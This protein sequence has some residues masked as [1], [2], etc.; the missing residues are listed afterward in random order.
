MRRSCS[1]P[2][3]RGWTPLRLLASL[4][5]SLQDARVTGYQNLGRRLSEQRLSSQKCQPYAELESSRSVRFS[6]EDGFDVI[7]RI[8]VHARADMDGVGRAGAGEMQL[9]LRLSVGLV[10]RVALRDSG[11]AVE[12]KAARE[13]ERTDSKEETS[14]AS[15]QCQDP[16]ADAKREKAAGNQHD[17]AD[18]KRN[19]EKRNPPIEF[20]R[21]NLRAVYGAHR[22]PGPHDGERHEKERR[23]GKLAVS[24]H[25]ASR[26]IRRI[27]L[28]L[29]MLRGRRT[30][31]F[32]HF[33]L[34]T[35]QVDFVND[36]GERRGLAARRTKHDVLRDIDLFERHVKTAL[37]TTVGFHF[38]QRLLLFEKHFNIFY[39]EPQ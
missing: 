39:Q 8:L 4:C 20:S 24:E 32:A 22:K 33:V 34:A 31:P 35:P 3:I 21:A 27:A 9:A 16:L 28:D 5:R 19:A 13:T 17:R 7:E 26:R 14:L 38:R 18:Q 12:R 23:L 36:F 10:A 25:D 30:E 37:R 2:T 1:N 15:L 6:P 11:L 29:E